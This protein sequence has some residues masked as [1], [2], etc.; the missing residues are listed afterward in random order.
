MFCGHTDLVYSAFFSPDGSLVLT[1]SGDCTAKIW[2]ATSG[3][4]LF[5]L[6]GVSP[7]LSAVFSPDGESVLTSHGASPSISTIWSVASGTRLLEVKHGDDKPYTTATF[8]FDGILLLT[9]GDRSAKIWSARTGACL[10]TLSGHRQQVYRAMFSRDGKLVIT[11]SYCNIVTLWKSSSGALLMHFGEQH[12]RWVPTAVFSPHGKWV[13]TVSGDSTAKI[14]STTAKVWGTRK[15]ICLRTFHG[16]GTDARA[17][18]SRDGAVLLT[19]SDDCAA[20]LWNIA[21]GVCMRMFTG[22]RGPYIHPALFPVFGMCV[23]TGSR[24]DYTYR[25]WSCA[26]EECISVLAG[27]TADV[28]TFVQ[29]PV[30]DAMQD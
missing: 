22:H 21:S 19:V 7:P 27:H 20:K 2:N 12:A 23:I 24:R 6:P 11:T 15:G 26:T 8:S 28:F 4:C 1:A 10:R 13:L 17:T 3:E 30:M 25:V 29:A 5:T 14:W 16:T 18:L 9:A